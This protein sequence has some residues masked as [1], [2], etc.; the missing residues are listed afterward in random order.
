M[1]ANNALT[2]KLQAWRSAVAA[3]GR[4]RRQ[5]SPRALL[6]RHLI[7]SG[8]EVGPGHHPFLVQQPGVHINYV[9]RWTREE[10][11]QL[12]PQLGPFAAD[13]ALEVDFNADRLS[14]VPSGSQDFV[15]ASHVIEHLA[16]PLGFVAEICRVLRPGGIALLLLPDR[17]RTRD[18]HRPPT[19]IDHLAAEY[20]DGTTQVSD[21]HLLEF[22]ED[23]GIPVPDSEADRQ[24]LL[25]V[26]RR[27]S[28]HVHC[29]DDLE[30][31]EVLLWGIDH[32]D[33]Q[34]EFVDGCIPFDG[35]P[36]SDIEFGYVL[37]RSEVSLDPVARRLRF[38]NAWSTWRE[39]QAI[40]LS[41]PNS[42]EVLLRA[43]RRTRSIGR[44]VK[45]RFPVGRG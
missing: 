7:G 4:P 28:I 25:D 24:R 38:S 6:C 34:W 13:L 36:P 26:H 39:A 8:I 9:D 27:R 3:A 19:T 23:R 41:G 44:S 5:I 18:R 10:G 45:G 30:F 29:W 33:T 37:R 35:A 20:A 21:L 11:G 15:I 31:V 2:S 14:P 16:E 43:Y 32:L 1:L 17:H 42:T 12:F 40:M 22:L